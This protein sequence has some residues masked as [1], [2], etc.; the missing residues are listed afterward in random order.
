MLIQRRV[1]AEQQRSRTNK[2]RAFAL[3][4][5][6]FGESRCFIETCSWD[7]SVTSPLHIA[8]RHM[9]VNPSR[10]VVSRLGCDLFANKAGRGRRAF[11]E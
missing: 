6:T 7:A 4:H 5:Q 3:F 8:L 11:L 1:K 2:K 10:F 9:L